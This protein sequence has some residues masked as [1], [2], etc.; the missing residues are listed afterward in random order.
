MGTLQNQRADAVEV[1]CLFLYVGHKEV[2]GP[3]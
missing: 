2:I 1:L 3:A